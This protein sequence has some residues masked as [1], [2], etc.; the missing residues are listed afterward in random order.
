MSGIQ[1]Q[2]QIPG[3]R[4]RVTGAVL[5]GR[6]GVFEKELFFPYLKRDRDVKLY[7]RES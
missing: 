5:Y 7:H 2:T 4:R 3:N 6:Y 1:G